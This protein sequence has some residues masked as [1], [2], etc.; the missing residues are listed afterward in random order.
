M[1]KTSRRIITIT[2]LLLGALLFLCCAVTACLVFFNSAPHF[3]L[4]AASGNE[5]LLVEPI[6]GEEIAVR[7]EV[8]RGESSQSVGRRLAE[9]GLIRNQLFW[10]IL[11][12]FGKEH[13]KTGS[14]RIEVPASQIAIHRILVSGK[15]ILLR[16]TVPEGLT[17]TKTAKLMEEAG[18]CPADTF[19]TAAIDPQIIERYRIPGISMEGYLYPDTY[20]FPPEFPAEKAVQAMVDTF[21]SRITDIDADTL[22]L[23]PEE[24]NRLIILASIVEREY[25]LDEEAPLMAGVFINRLNIN[26]A[27][28]SCATVVY[29]ITEVQG[30]PHPEMLYNR[31]IEIRDP[32]NTYIRPGLPPGPICSPGSVALRAVLNPSE[33]NYMYFR[34]VNQASGKHYFSNTLD[35]HIRASVLYVKGGP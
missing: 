33:T 34:L 21:F 4:D 23:P 12:R 19:V 5:G 27:L 20:L 16:V 15:Q 28:Q 11:C 35:D 26:M 24:L 17:L 25:R 14:Y 8:R 1:H 31:D 2:A 6:D 9:S 10:D 30:R 22:S 7:F 29:V 13:I 18:I 32:Y 3:S